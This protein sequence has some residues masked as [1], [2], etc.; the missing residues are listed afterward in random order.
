MR[1]V[2][3]AIDL[4]FAGSLSVVLGALYVIE[5]SA[6]PEIKWMHEAAIQYGEKQN[7]SHLPE[8]PQLYFTTHLNGGEQSHQAGLARFVENHEEFGFDSAEISLGASIAIAAMNGWWAALASTSN[9]SDLLEVIKTDNPGS[10]IQKE[11][12]N[13]PPVP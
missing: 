7:K 13:R 12:N 10:L 11:T 1:S 9:C 6:A 3:S 4:A 5:A 2:S 8:K